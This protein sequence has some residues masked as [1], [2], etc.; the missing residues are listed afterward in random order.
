MPLAG[1]PGAVVLVD[2]FVKNFAPG[3]FSHTQVFDIV[4]KFIPSFLK[5][6]I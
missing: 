5:N 3:A 6:S 1:T 4:A 2:N